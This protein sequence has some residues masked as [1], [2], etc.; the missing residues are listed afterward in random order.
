MYILTEEELIFYKTKTS[1]SRLIINWSNFRDLEA[2]ARKAI[3]AKHP[4]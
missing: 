3:R 4:V 1:K 2:V